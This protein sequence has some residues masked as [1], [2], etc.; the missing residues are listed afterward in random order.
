MTRGHRRSKHRHASVSP[1]R[2][3]ARV[4]KKRQNSMGP[5]PS[6]KTCFE[7]APMQQFECVVDV[8]ISSDGACSEISE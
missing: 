4:S 6:G 3:K 2:P 7:E 5:M 8:A 1:M